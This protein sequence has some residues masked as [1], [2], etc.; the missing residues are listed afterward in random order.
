[1]KVEVTA[2]YRDPGKT[3]RQDDSQVLARS[4]VVEVYGLNCTWES[5]SL[6]QHP[7]KFACRVGRPRTDRLQPRLNR[8][9]LASLGECSYLGGHAWVST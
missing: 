8:A 3:S 5:G 6:D 9:S 4:L 7:Q 1:M 2:V